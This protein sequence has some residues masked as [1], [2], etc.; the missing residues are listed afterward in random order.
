MRCHEVIARVDAYLAGELPEARR[1]E[2][3]LHVEAC[4][5]CR[6]VL[7]RA[8]RLESLLAKTSVPPVPDRFAEWVLSRAVKRRKQ[9]TPSWSVK[10]W[11]LTVSTPMRAAA[12]ALL[13]VGTMSG[14]ILGW[15]ASRTTSPGATAQAR[16][17]DSVFAG[18]GLDTLGDAPDGSL[19]EG[20]LAL[21]DGRNGEGR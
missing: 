20:Y 19:A 13:L 6:R 1:A 16:Q 7:E 2:V 9:K 18:Y 12:A 14:V 3:T 11:W 4:N 17:A 5:D 10:T 21:L 8:Q 15:N